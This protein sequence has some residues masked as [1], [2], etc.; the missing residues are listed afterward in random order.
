MPQDIFAAS[1]GLPE[2]E[3]SVFSR[4]TTGLS[5]VQVLVRRSSVVPLKANPMARGWR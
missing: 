3:C 2:A 1:L 5:L 4:R